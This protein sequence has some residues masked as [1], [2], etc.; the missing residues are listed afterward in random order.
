[1]SRYE[2]RCPWET[3]GSMKSPDPVII[4]IPEVEPI[5]HNL[6]R[7][8]HLLMQGRYDEE[9]YR[10]AGELLRKLTTPREQL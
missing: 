2:I 10:L 4:E 3:L 5:P 9:G 8:A 6:R 1:M 7:A